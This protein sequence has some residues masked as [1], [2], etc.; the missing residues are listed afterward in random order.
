MEHT[1]VIAILKKSNL[2]ITSARIAILDILQ[3]SS[4]PLSVEM[5]ETRLKH[6]RINHVT[7]YRTVESLLKLGVIS[8][9]DLRKESVFYEFN[10]IHHHH[11]HI[12]C[13]GCGVLEDFSSC[14]MESTTSHVLSKSKKFK[15]INDHSFELFGL[16]NSCMK[17]NA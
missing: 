14:Q 1:H 2:K 5:I 3:S 10:N 16:C 4:T 11:H 9:V 17:K 8:R 13:T 15:V 12:V 7:I 6:K